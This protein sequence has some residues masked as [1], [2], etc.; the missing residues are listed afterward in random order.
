MSSGGYPLASNERSNLCVFVCVCVRPT[1]Q[2]KRQAFDIHKYG[3]SV[4]TKVASMLGPSERARALKAKKTAMRHENADQVCSGNDR[5]LL[6]GW[7]VAVVVAVAVGVVRG[8]DT[9]GRGLFSLCSFVSLSIPQGGQRGGKV[10]VSSPIAININ[11][12]L[13][14]P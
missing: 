3:N 2:E 5:R 11:N 1:R 9:R 4:L 12:S 14:C 13:S 7:G 6:E 8:L 10:W